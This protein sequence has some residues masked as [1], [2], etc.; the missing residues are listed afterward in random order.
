MNPT[1]DQRAVIEYRDSSLLVSASAGSG[2]TEVLARRCA[3]LLADEQSSV[4]VSQLLVMTFTRAAAAELRARIGRALRL[5]WSMRRTTRAA[6]WIARQ[7]ALLDTAEIGTIDSWCQRIVR[8]N[9]AQLG[10]DPRFSILNEQQVQLLRQ[11]ALDAVFD[12]VYTSDEEIAATVRVWIEN[13]ARPT[14]RALRDLVVQLNQFREHLADP[15]R[16]FS[17]RREECAAS[18]EMLSQRA[19]RNVLDAICRECEQQLASLPPE[20]GFTE[21]V[22]YR[23]FLEELLRT[24]QTDGLSSAAS[25]IGEFRWRRARRGESRDAVIKEIKTKW[26]E[27]RL[28][29]RFSPERFRFLS[30]DESFAA[31]RILLLIELEARFARHIAQRQALRNAYTF[32][33]IQRFTLQLLTQTDDS[34]NRT[35]APLAIE[36]Q[37]RYAHV[38]IDE[39]Q[40][41]SEIQIELL[42]LITRSRPER[43]NCFMVGDIKQSIYGFRQAEPQ[44]FAEIMRNFRRSAELG[45]TL[46]LTSSFRSHPALID[47]INRIFSRLFDESFGGTAYTSAEQLTAAREEIENST[48]AAEPR[49]QIYVLPAP[50]AKEVESDDDTDGADAEQE[51]DAEDDRIE[52]EAR[53]VARRIREALPRLSVPARDTTGKLVLRP[54]R[55]TDFA[56]LLRAA[57]GKAIKVVNILRE[58]GVNAATVG[59]EE[60]LDST[61]GE[62]ILNALRVIVNRRQDLALA[63]FL[64]SP[65]VGLRETDLLKIRR[66]FPHGDFSAACEQY[67]TH[68]G[69]EGSTHQRLRAA[70]DRLDR[71]TRAARDETVPALLDRILRETRYDLFVRGIARG[72]HRTARLNAI[73][74]F[75]RTQTEAP[76]SDLAA[77][78]SFVDQLDELSAAPVTSIGAEAQTVRIMTI[79]QSK[80]LEFPFVILIGAGSRFN[81]RSSRQALI[82][83]KQT[84]IGLSQIDFVARRR[85][86]NAVHLTASLRQALRDREEELRLLYVAATRARETLWVV[87]HGNADREFPFVNPSPDAPLSA[88]LR[89]SAACA[90]DWLLMSTAR[91]EP[92]PDGSPL[93]AIQT[94]EPLQD[95]RPATRFM[96][97]L[98][99]SES[100]VS[101]EW[102]EHAAVLIG[103]KNAPEFPAVVSVSALKSLALGD[104]DADPETLLTPFETRLDPPR[105]VMGERSDGRALGTAVHRFLQHVD[106]RELSDHNSIVAEFARLSA[107]GRISSQEL[108]LIPLESLIWLAG[109]P[110]G[111]LLRNEYARTRREVPFVLSLPVRHADTG[112]PLQ[113]DAILT[114]GVI[115]CLIERDRDLVLIDFKTDRIHS[116]REWNERLRIYGAQISV[117]AHAAERIFGKPVQDAW[118]VFLREA[119]VERVLPSLDFLTMLA[120]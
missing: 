58:E 42:W 115:D 3:A 74:E 92:A 95:E 77:F 96:A 56:V 64:R 118:L 15:D 85:I 43:G 59:R 111:E 1:P 14:D 119:R 54:A 22:E 17:A 30:D 47:A 36:L 32:S 101:K 23:S 94:A 120:R 114:R 29:K 34:G 2:K 61:E 89:A 79:H 11:E 33:D 51:D 108:S 31:R 52:R 83:D 65:L 88:L 48:L 75:V 113:T 69:P 73:R 99:Q 45:K 38:L 24:A 40:D 112:G 26:F 39:C 80:G 35:P 63:S 106:L 97:T 55:L 109:S 5:E 6:D 87:G 81:E 66:A 10:I 93:F 12:W 57:Q 70:F 49:I 13:M 116:E 41:T 16:W 7:I 19:E 103:A 82:C 105:F 91:L 90:L 20:S 4:E 28:K 107:S 102:S 8:E 78:V 100:D 84:G 110:V 18:P 53:W 76:G 67:L 27:N 50:K 72:A 46:N 71:W 21:L 104:P 60:V 62:D 9:A 44:H 98:P 68:A 25:A 86:R 37:R 117:Y